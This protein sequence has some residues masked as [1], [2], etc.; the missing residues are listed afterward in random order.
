MT[1]IRGDLPSKLKTNF[2]TILIEPLV[3][4]IETIDLSGEDC[5]AG[6][7]VL[8]LLNFLL[9]LASFLIVFVENLDVSFQ[10]VH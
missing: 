9:K 8:I 2:A 1:H 10:L 7:I 5:N 3:F 4:V 6:S